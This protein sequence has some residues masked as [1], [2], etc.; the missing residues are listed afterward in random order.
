[1][2]HRL[3]HAIRWLVCLLIGGVLMSSCSKDDDLELPPAST[4]KGY[5]YHNFH[6]LH[7]SK[8]LQDQVQKMQSRNAIMAKSGTEDHTFVI[9]TS[10]VQILE[11]ERYVSYTFKANRNPVDEN[12]L[13]N[14]VLTIYNDDSFHQMYVSYPILVDEE[15]VTYDIDNAIA[16][17]ITGEA[18]VQKNTCGASQIPI[19]SW[20]EDCVDYECGSG[21]HSGSSQTDSCSLDELGT[22]YGPTTICVGGWVTNCLDAGDSSSGGDGSDQ[23]GTGGTGGSGTPND[24]SDPDLTDDNIGQIGVIPF[25]PPSQDVDYNV[26]TLME[27]V[28]IPEVKDLIKD[29][30]NEVTNRFKEDGR[31]YNVDITTNN[32]TR[33]LNATEIMPQSIRKKSVKFPP[34]DFNTLIKVHL[35]NK[36]N[37][38]REQSGAVKQ[39]KITVPLFSSDDIASFI[40]FFNRREA[41]NIT[42]EER[43]NNEDISS[44]LVAEPAILNE[45][46]NIQTS[47]IYALKISDPDRVKELKERFN[48]ETEL[49]AFKKLYFEQILNSVCSFGDNGCYLGEFADFL[50]NYDNGKGFGISIYVAIETFG[51]ITNWVKP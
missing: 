22:Q 33:T 32:G 20:S 19:T 1:M 45:E 18:L 39:T 36:F 17:Q 21:Q 24:P 40:G 37:N 4:L 7:K 31:M 11:A 51:E 50:E 29:L 25:I 15:T 12:Y 34:I 47:G 9:D 23:T 3:Q 16:T 27:Q 6:K 28:R 35:H 42:N 14:Y 48:T 44:I 30:K 49:A 5:S 41:L 2:K 43:V 13:D 8:T 10:I 46:E 38:R 26:E